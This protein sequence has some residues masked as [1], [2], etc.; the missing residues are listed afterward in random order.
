M[1][2]NRSTSKNHKWVTHHL[3]LKYFSLKGK[4]TISTHDYLRAQNILEIPTK[5]S[6]SSNN[7]IW[8]WLEYISFW[9]IL[10]SKSI[11]NSW[12]KAHFIIFHTSFHFVGAIGHKYNFHSWHGVYTLYPQLTTFTF[13]HLY[14]LSTTKNL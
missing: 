8:T 3:F 1:I 12:I 7:H 6:I 11:W 14:R 13:K 9:I 10:F 2:G 4:Y 5:H